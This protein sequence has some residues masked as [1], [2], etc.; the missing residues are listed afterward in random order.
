MCGKSEDV[1]KKPDYTVK[2]R[3]SFIKCEAMQKERGKASLKLLLHSLTV[4]EGMPRLYSIS[5]LFQHIVSIG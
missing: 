3:Q 4:S 5:S 2:A 1:Q